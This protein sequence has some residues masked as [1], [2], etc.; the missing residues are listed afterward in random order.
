MQ[1]LQLITRVLAL[2]MIITWPV[3]AFAQSSGGPYRIAVA[4]IAG[5]GGTLYGGPFVFSGTIGQPATAWL[6][7][8]GYSLHDGFWAPAAPPGDAIFADGFDP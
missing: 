8:S 5:S 2:G 4:T 1:R 7:A 6:S 3:L